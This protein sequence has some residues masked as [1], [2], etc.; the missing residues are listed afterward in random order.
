MATCASVGWRGFAGQRRRKFVDDALEAE[1]KKRRR[2]GDAGNAWSSG[3]R[4]PLGGVSG[5]GAR[6]DRGRVGQAGEPEEE[7]EPKI[8]I[9]DDAAGAEVADDIDVGEIA[10][11]QE[12]GRS[13]RRG[14]L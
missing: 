13:P 12:G 1:E 14:G 2:S 6:E 10:V 7:V 3:P 5:P 8:S 11:S 9:M 4:D